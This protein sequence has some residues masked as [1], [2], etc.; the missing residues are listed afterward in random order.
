MW[1]Q[2]KLETWEGVI[3][4]LEFLCKASQ[5]LPSCL[6]LEAVRDQAH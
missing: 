1:K 2:W 4:T 6:D 3:K 5:H